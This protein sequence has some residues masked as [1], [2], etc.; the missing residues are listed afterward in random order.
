MSNSNSSSPSGT[1]IDPSRVSLVKPADNVEHVRFLDVPLVAGKSH[2]LEVEYPLQGRTIIFT[3]GGVR[4]GL[5][6]NDLAPRSFLERYAPANLEFDQSPLSLSIRLS[7]AMSDHRLFANGT[8]HPITANAWRIDFPAY[9]T[10]SSSYVHL[11]NRLVTVKSEI[12]DG[13]EAAVP[14]TVYGNDAYAAPNRYPVNLASFSKYRRDTTRD[15]YRMGMLLLSELDFL[16]RERGGLRPVLRALYLAK[17]RQVID[18]PFFQQFLEQQTGLD[19]Q[20]IFARYVYGQAVGNIRAAARDALYR[21][22]DSHFSLAEFART[23]D[24]APA[25]ISRSFNPEELSQL[26]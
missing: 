6:L 17:R 1:T 4:L 13:Q 5:F 7:G 16:L 10:C 26:V 12:F 2:T 14:A 20:Q 21:R 24:L 9:F 11:T 23:H 22:R 25:V 3:N 8:M 18:T 19:L 15:A